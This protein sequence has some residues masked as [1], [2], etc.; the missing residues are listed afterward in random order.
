[1]QPHWSP[2]PVW[3]EWPGGAEI[4]DFGVCIGVCLHFLTTECSAAPVMTARRFY[5]YLLSSL[6]LFFWDSR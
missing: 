2:D 6:G 3:K 5:T 4:L 1:M